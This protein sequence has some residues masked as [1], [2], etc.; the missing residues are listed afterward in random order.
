LRSRIATVGSTGERFCTQGDLVQ[1]FSVSSITVR[2]ALHDLEQEGLIYQINGRGVFV[3]EGGHALSGSVARKRTWVVSLLL[4]DRLPD[5]LR[6]RFYAPVVDAFEARARQGG[7]R[8]ISE[9]VAGQAVGDLSLPASVEGLQVDGVALLRS[10]RNDFLLR[11]ME[12]RVPAVLIDFASDELNLDAV[13]ID[14]RGGARAAVEHLIGL[15]HRRIA[16]LAGFY[17]TPELQSR[18]VTDRLGGYRETLAA[19][20]L[21]CSEELIVSARTP[22]ERAR[23]L[24][25]MLSRPNRPTALFC[26]SDWWVPQAVTMACELGL[27]VPQDLSIVGFGGTPEL[28]GMQGLALTTLE[29][30]LARIGSEAARMLIERINGLSTPARRVVVSA[31]LAVGNTTAPPSSSLR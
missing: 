10:Q 11:L 5:L 23:A 22:E 16:H 8:V 14:N 30:D 28:A 26:F 27:C 1:E 3:A 13:V 19:H 4:R 15:G 24:K 25:T 29:V 17:E 7:L 18:S 9:S 21:P 2:R 20:G 6:S 31:T 12:R